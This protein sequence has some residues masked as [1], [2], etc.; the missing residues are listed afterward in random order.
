MNP[1]GGLA[2]RAWAIHEIERKF[3]GVARFL[4]DSGNFSDNPT[5]QGSVQTKALLDAMERLGY[6]AV[7][8]GE[9]D[10]Q[11]GYPAFLE[12]VGS[13]GFPFVSAN[14]VR[15]DTKAPVFRPSVV[16]ESDGPASAKRMRIGVVGA[17]RFN[18]TFRK[19]GP[20][21][22]E[23][24]VVA[25]REVVAAEVEKLKSSK[26]D[27]VVL[28][29]A[30]PREDARRLALDVPGI[31]F[32]VGS[33]GGDYTT[34]K[35]RQ[36]NT[37]IVYSGNQG[38]RLGETRVY[39]RAGT[40]EQDTK[41]HM[42]TTAYPS[43]ESMLEFVNSIPRTTPAP[44][45]AVSA[46]PAEPTAGPYIGSEACRGCHIKQGTDWAAS[47]H[48]SALAT[49]DKKS[50]STGT[51]CMQCH[52]TGQGAAG[53]FTSR[54]GTPALANVGCEACH[55][56]G[57]DHAARVDLPYGKV[58]V[59]TCTGCHDKANSPKFDV[60][61]YLPRVNHRGAAAR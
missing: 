3:Q 56:P 38:K 6:D 11:R 8:V 29:A 25:P 10:V 45:P 9:R 39:L 16:I 53:G 37:W 59:A 57:R 46:A 61:T 30:L 4:L 43:D 40:V 60:Y 31:D 55:G 2:R 7:N 19:P 42:L 5:P 21:G 27:L 14:I 32:V 48:A 54:E 44:L 58:T 12:L 26:V 34:S 28:L 20:E 35:E 50:S 18:P 36:G 51:A 47:A 41:L 33:Y 24:I 52:V 49:L 17:V 1:A 22:T 15:A 23:M 13:R